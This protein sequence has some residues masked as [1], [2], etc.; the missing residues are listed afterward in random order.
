MLVG[1]AYF[2]VMLMFGEWVKMLKE[3]RCNDKTAD[4][5]LIMYVNCQAKPDQSRIIVKIH[6]TNIPSPST[7]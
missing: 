7:V 3:K 4:L 2:S 5:F 1:P 6:K